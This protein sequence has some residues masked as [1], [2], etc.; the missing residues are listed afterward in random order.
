[1]SQRNNGSRNPQS[2]M[3][4]MSNTPEQSLQH[5]HHRG[6]KRGHSYGGPVS[7]TTSF[8]HARLEAR[9]SHPT[10]DIHHDG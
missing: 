10:R 6:H 9:P 4:S 7:P 2:P 3:L 5:S 8:H 1:M